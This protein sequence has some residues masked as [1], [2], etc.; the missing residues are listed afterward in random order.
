[1]QA[2]VHTTSL[3]RLAEP[4]AGFCLFVFLTAN[5]QPLWAMLTTCLLNVLLITW[6]HLRAPSNVLASLF[7]LVCDVTWEHEGVGLTCCNPSIPSDPVVY[8]VD[9]SAG[10]SGFVFPHL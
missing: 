8:A 5:G 7:P 2:F 3:Y 6:R 4:G 9:T 10:F 1:M